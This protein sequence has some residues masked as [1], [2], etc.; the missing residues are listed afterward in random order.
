MTTFLHTFAP[1]LLAG[2]GTAAL[3]AGVGLFASSRPAHTAGGPI[4]VNVANT[5]QNHDADNPAQQPFQILMQPSSDTTA[6]VSQ[7]F[8]VPAHKRLVLEFVSS[9]VN[10]YPSKGGA[11]SY[12]TTT[13]GGQTVT[14]YFANT[15]E[16]A[17]RKSQ[18]VRL[19]ADPG[20]DV[21]VGANTY[22][23]NGVGTDTELS[24]YY[25]DVP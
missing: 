22:G 10:E 2:F 13:A 1:R 5:V 15:Y 6:S 24:G 9:E 4:S 17:A 7:S 16:S 20:T 14:Y 3:V 23:G 18:V 12:L 19:Y 21:T 8:S 25:V 11:Y